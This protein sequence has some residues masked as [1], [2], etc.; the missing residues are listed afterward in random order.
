MVV[1]ETIVL[2]ALLAASEVI[3]IITKG[4]INGFLYAC[5]NGLVEIGVIDASVLY[6]AEET[7]GR[8]INGDGVVGD[9]SRK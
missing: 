1:V 5:I 4:K 6:R 3:P 8:D 2:S 7:G 9:P